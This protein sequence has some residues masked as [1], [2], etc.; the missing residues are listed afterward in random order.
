MS[1]PYY[2]YDTK[3]YGIE[4]RGHAIE[5]VFDKMLLVLNRASLLVDGVEVD[6]ERIFFGEHHLET[7]LDDGT[8]IRVKLGTGIVG[9]LTKAVLIA[10]D[11]TS[12]S[13]SERASPSARPPA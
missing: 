13:L 8:R 2:G 1:L 12:Y 11:G 5:L 6:K 3:H 7:T 9:E 4:Y 10:E